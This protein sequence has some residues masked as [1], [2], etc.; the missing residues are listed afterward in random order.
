MKDDEE[1]ELVVDL[2][3]VGSPQS[4][5]L[6]SR[7]IERNF[8]RSVLINRGRDTAGVETKSTSV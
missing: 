6:S 5:P 7:D 3:Q 4:S 8:R 2:G 1:E